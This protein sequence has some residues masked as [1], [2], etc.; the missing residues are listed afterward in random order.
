MQ[1]VV[2]A[3]HQI[4]AVLYFDSDAAGQ[5]A[6]ALRGGAAL[7]AFRSIARQPYFTP[8]GAR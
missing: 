5:I 6:Y 7:A 1:Q 8:S 3:D 4:K 2:Q